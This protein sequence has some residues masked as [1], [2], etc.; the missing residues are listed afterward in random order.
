MELSDT[1]PPTVV[2]G[3]PISQALFSQAFPGQALSSSSSSFRTSMSSSSTSSH[4]FLPVKFEGIGAWRSSSSI[5]LWVKCAPGE[6]RVAVEEGVGSSEGSSSHRGAK[7]VLESLFSQSDCPPRDG[8][9]AS[10]SAPFQNSSRSKEEEVEEMD[11]GD[12]FGPLLSQKECQDRVE[13]DGVGREGVATVSISHFDSYSVPTAGTSLL[14]SRLQTR[15]PFVSPVSPFPL[16]PT[17]PPPFAQQHKGAEE[18]GT[19]G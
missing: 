16:G 9:A 2:E 7:T 13:K 5:P 10:S 17:V 3:L 4:F 19:G 6:R 12:D 18:M 11:L 1:P 14:T 8:Q 15:N